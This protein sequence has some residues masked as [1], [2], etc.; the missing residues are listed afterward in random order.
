[1]ADLRKDAYFV[2]NQDGQNYKVTLDTVEKL[3]SP[4]LSAFSGDIVPSADDTYSL[5]TETNR[6]KEIHVS[7]N[8]IFLGGMSL[9]DQAGKLHIEK[10]SDADP[11]VTFDLS[12]NS[13]GSLADVNTNGVQDAQILK[14]DQASGEWVPAAA[15]TGALTFVGI[16][17]TGEGDVLAP[18]GLELT[19]HFYLVDGTH[20][21]NVGDSA[22]WPGL[23]ADQ[24]VTTGAMVVLSGV[25]WVILDDVVGGGG[26][27]QIH[28]DTTAITIDGTDPAH[29][30]LDLDWGRNTEQ[31][32]P[33]DHLHTEY[34]ALTG[35]TMAGAIDMD[36]NPINVRSVDTVTDNDLTISRQGTTKVTVGDAA[37][38]TTTDIK[39][40]TAGLN[41]LG[42]D[43]SE[44]FT[45]D[46]G[47]VQYKGV[48]EDEDHVVTKQWVE[49][50][51]D[52]VVANIGDAG[53]AH[54][55]GTFTF[56]GNQIVPSG[57]WVPGD[58]DWET[59]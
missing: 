29:P 53:N 43:D 4:D 19:G 12:A 28:S 54:K 24:E 23:P 7:A 8:T 47:S 22:D 31:V 55:L 30:R 37:L 20:T 44:L 48:I 56:A 11:E 59:T 58:R 49:T 34:L 51:V 41:I 9:E 45:L 2:V 17:G 5:G 16:I 14:Y 13:I 40:G 57:G 46:N 10:A 32:P 26:V 39:F 1:M 36:A 18:T 33:G 15:V 3:L 6:W 42:S 27:T 50:L 35:G 52:E 21:L 25:N 38:T